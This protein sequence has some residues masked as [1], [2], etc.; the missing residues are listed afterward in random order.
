MYKP[1]TPR[2][3]GYKIDKIKKRLIIYWDYPGNCFG[4]IS[5]GIYI[6]DATKPK[7]AKYIPYLVEPIPNKSFQIKMTSITKI[8]E[9]EIRSNVSDAVY[10]KIESHDEDSD[11]S[12]NADNENKQTGEGQ[13][14]MPPDIIGSQ[15]EESSKKPNHVKLTLVWKFDKH[16]E[17]MMRLYSDGLLVFEAREQ[18]IYRQHPIIFRAHN[19]ETSWN[20]DPLPINKTFKFQ[21]RSI[22]VKQK[23]NNRNSKNF[24]NYTN[25]ISAWSEPKI[26]TT[27]LKPITK[28]GP[29]KHQPSVNVISEQKSQQKIQKKMQQNVQPH[30]QP[31]IPPKPEPK[32]E[33][34]YKPEPEIKEPPK[35]V[36]FNVTIH[37]IH[38]LMDCTIQ[39]NDQMQYREFLNVYQS[40]G[41][42]KPLF[43]Q[44]QMLL[45]RL[46]GEK[47]YLDPQRWDLL[48]RKGM[49]A[50]QSKIDVGYMPFTPKI[51]NIIEGAKCA[52]KI[53]IESPIADVFQASFE[54]KNNKH[55]I[56]DVCTN[57]GF[58]INAKLRNEGQYKI[59]VFAFNEFGKSN[60]SENYPKQQN[61]WFPKKKEIPIM[62]NDSDMV[63]VYLFATELP[64]N[65]KWYVLNPYGTYD[66]FGFTCISKKNFIFRCVW[67][68]NIVRTD[69]VFRIFEKNEHGKKLITNWD[70]NPKMDARDK[71]FTIPKDSKVF[72]LDFNKRSGGVTAYVFNYSYNNYVPILHNILSDILN[73]IGNIFAPYESFTIGYELT[74]VFFPNRKGTALLNPKYIREQLKK[75]I[76][77]F[78]YAM[79]YFVQNSLIIA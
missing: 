12:S 11:T 37:N 15:S 56:K 74:R 17:S 41:T 75:Y 10:I 49:V 7:I 3:I 71:Y 18:L 44:G 73:D 54:P 42:N 43:I 45:Y 70:A 46:K 40:K 63:V 65:G 76:N 21:M 77:H 60:W 22:E 13:Y 26:V 33:P 4:L 78:H 6:N 58:E 50:Q 59:R 69:K 38:T 5:Y 20:L 23:I 8:G 27:E 29:V 79:S 64:S 28:G 14:I 52:I 36:P 19:G 2:N 34:E 67:D 47:Q 62:E 32:P 16:N 39:I 9:N 57:K 51:K 68:N 30:I 72:F 66:Y 24:K 53:E 61:E 48:M 25:Q 55:K 1:N 31:H 35:P